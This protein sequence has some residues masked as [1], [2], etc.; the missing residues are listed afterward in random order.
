MKSNKFIILALAGLLVVFVGCGGGSNDVADDSASIKIN[1]PNEI[2]NPKIALPIEG[3]V[4]QLDTVNMTFVLGTLPTNASKKAGKFSVFLDADT[5]IVDKDGNQV[6]IKNYD[7]VRIEEGATDIN[8]NASKITV[9]KISEGTTLIPIDDSYS[10]RI[11][12]NKIPD[13]LKSEIGTDLPKSFPN[14]TWMAQP[15]EN[16]PTIPAAKIIELTNSNWSI[17]LLDNPETD[18]KYSV[19]ITDRNEFEWTGSVS[20]DNKI[21]QN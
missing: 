10:K 1:A 4:G 20:K 5:M 18:E 11:D 16:H 13:L 14:G 3:F 9:L 2:T 7:K 21:T 17:Y 15:P 12:F 6:D 8:I 19:T